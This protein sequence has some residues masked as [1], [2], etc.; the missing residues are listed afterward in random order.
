M[1]KFIHALTKYKT[2]YKDNFIA[3]ALNI[4]FISISIPALLSTTNATCLSSSLSYFIVLCRYA[5]L[6]TTFLLVLKNSLNSRFLILLGLWIF[7]FGITA[8]TTPDTIPYLPHSLARSLNSFLIAYFLLVLKDKK[9][10]MDILTI[11]SCLYHLI[12]V[13]FLCNLTIKGQLSHFCETEKGN[14]MA[15]S[16]SMLPFTLCIIYNA[17]K[18]NK[19]FYWIISLIGFIVLLLFGCRGALASVIVYFFVLY[20]RKCYTSRKLSRFIVFS[21]LISFITFISIIFLMEFNNIIKNEIGINSYIINSFFRDPSNFG[22][23]RDK[24]WKKSIDG[25]ITNIHFKGLHADTVYLYPSNYSH[26]IILELLYDFGIIIGFIITF[27]LFA[28]VSKTILSP[29]D[30]ANN[31]IKIYLLSTFW[32]KLMVS[33]TFMLE[34]WFWIW[35][36]LILDDLTISFNEIKQKRITIC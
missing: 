26:N 22:S 14:Y 5:I 7:L 30:N 15:F 6:G 17:F 28:L 10:F 31:D 18:T 32:V 1:D 27:L 34:S 13:L 21:L 35:L 8:I 4:L 33:N 20:F 2:V 12:L 24:I 29:H 19:I 9:K 16:Y 3:I 36:I 23:G 11:F 25:A